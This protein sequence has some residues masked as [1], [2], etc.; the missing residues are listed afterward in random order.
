MD[1]D[2]F[3]SKFSDLYNDLRDQYHA[4]VIYDG[5]TVAG[6]GDLNAS[7]S[8]F[9]GSQMFARFD[10]KTCA[11]MIDMLKDIR[12]TARQCQEVNKVPT[13]SPKA[14]CRPVITID[15]SGLPDVDWRN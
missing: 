6:P 13:T 14:K 12:N 9:L 11:L 3:L 10:A 5:V 1:E 7:G 15:G 2:A 8:M 4:T